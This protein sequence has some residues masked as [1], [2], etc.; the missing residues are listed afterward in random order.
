MRRS[1]RPIDYAAVHELAP[2]PVTMGRNSVK[3]VTRALSAV[4][5][6]HICMITASEMAVEEV[7]CGSR[8]RWL[9]SLFSTSLSFRP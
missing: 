9:V 4:S 1:L 8:K 3:M 6:R 7:F 2:T 5:F